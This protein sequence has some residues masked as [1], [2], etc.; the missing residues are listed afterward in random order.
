MP[1][2]AFDNVDGIRDR[3]GKG[4]SV[5]ETDCNGP[6][7]GTSLIGAE[8]AAERHEDRSHAER[9]NEENVCVH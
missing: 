7:E 3:H 4:Q 6:E 5:E 2:R 9:R 8:C 1:R